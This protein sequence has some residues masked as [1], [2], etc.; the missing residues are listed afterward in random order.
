MGVRRKGDA[1][2][3]RRPAGVLGVKG[4]AGIGDHLRLAPLGR[5]DEGVKILHA[6]V[7]EE[8]KDMGL[9]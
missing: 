3:V 6:C 5:H 4:L 9:S 7:A 1:S 8:A 2:A